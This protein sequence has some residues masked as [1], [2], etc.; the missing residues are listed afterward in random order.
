MFVRIQCALKNKVEIHLY[1]KL[2]QGYSEL[3]KTESICVAE[4]IY[5]AYFLVMF[6]AKSIG[7]Y[8]GQTLYNI[9]IVIGMLLFGLKIIMTKHT[10]FEY[11]CISCLGILSCIV[12]YNTGEKGLLFYMKKVI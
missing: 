11:M 10:V 7:L 3:K 1:M 8:E 12:Y 9:S 4:I 5:L 6:G 2:G